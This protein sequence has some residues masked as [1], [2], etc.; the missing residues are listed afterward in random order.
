MVKLGTIQ[1][2]NGVV[3]AVQVVSSSGD[4]FSD[5][6]E[7]SAGYY[8]STS[9]KS[10]GTMWAVGSNSLADWAMG[11]ILNRETPVQ[12]VK[13]DGSGLSDVVGIFA[14]DSPT[15]FLTNDGTVWSTTSSGFVEEMNS[16]TH[17]EMRL[18]KFT[19][20]RLLLVITIRCI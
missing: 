13:A 16:T 17:F 6:I 19:Y 18:G 5:V 2:T 7:I 15:N 11:P 10:D 20:L 8:H 14:A 4:S 9:L 3:Y 12:V 1:P